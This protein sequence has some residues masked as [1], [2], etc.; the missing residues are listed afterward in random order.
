M[1]ELR[2]RFDSVGDQLRDL[3]IAFAELVLVLI[4]ALLVSRWVR[5]RIRRR[6]A[7]APSPTLS[8]V[9][10]NSAAVGVYVV[11]L[12]VV[13]ALWG[14]TWSGLVT[15]LSIS[16]V[17]VAFGFQDLLRSVVGGVLVIFERPFAIGDRIKIREIEGRVEQIDLR[18]TVVRADSGDR[19]TIPNALIFS[20]PVINRSPTRV[21]R[22]LVVSGIEGT[23]AGVRQRALQALADLPGLDGI[24]QIAV[25]TR[26]SLRRVHRT[27]DAV[28]GIER[29]HGHESNETEPIV[30][31]FRVAWNRTGD[32]AS[33]AAVKERLTVA[34]PGARIS[35]AN[36]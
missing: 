15:A 29:I 13:L 14:L 2:D 19:I 1:D 23:P 30:T 18:T 24:P 20:D 17:A 21:R 25:R 5:R 12:T 27:L 7:S 3:G 34:F 11:A 9:L 4:V 33:R 35:E 28:P 26:K 16:T 6:A 32:G 8:V 10:E 36:W 22:V 31:S